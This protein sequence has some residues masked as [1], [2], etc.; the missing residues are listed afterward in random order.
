MALLP[1][2]PKQQKALVA[3]A[4]SLTVLYFANR[5][6]Y[7]DAKAEAEATQER[8]EM[9]QSQNR[10]A[11]AMAISAGEDLEE[12]M[13]TYERHIAQL[14]QLIPQSSEVPALL[15]QISVVAREVGV[16]VPVIRPEPEQ[17]GAFYTSQNFELEVRGEYHDVGRFLTRI[18]SL[19]R[20]VA[21]MDVSLVGF[22]DARGEYDSP[23]VLSFRIQTYLA[24]TPRQAGTP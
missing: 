1:D 23:I 3:I 8:I 20:I 13:A 24:P 19:P 5:L 2:D 7:S 21:P 6:W 11:Q 17:P 4:V 10:T 15:D 9:L 22:T 14:E 18:A 16:E 12:R